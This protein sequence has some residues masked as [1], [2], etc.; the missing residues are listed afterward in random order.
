MEHDII[1]RNGIKFIVFKILREIPYIKHGFSTRIGGISE[2][3]YSYLNLGIKTGDKQN[4]VIENIKRFALS[5]GVNY[6]GLVI[7]DQIHG[8]KIEIVGNKDHASGC[9]KQKKYNG[10]DGLVT[11][12]PNTPLMATF[13]D[14]VPIFFA[15]PI[16]KVIGISHAGWKGTELKIAAKTIQIM[17]N[18]YGSKTDEIVVVIGPSIGKCCYEVD[19]VVVERFNKGFTDTSTFIFPKGKGKYQIDLWEA[20]RIILKEMGISNKNIVI[21]NLCT[22]CNLD[23]FYSHRKENG[24]TGRMGAIIQLI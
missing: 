8:D 20:N 3:A 1:N 15:D 2:G 6:E 11:N 23:L 13:A 18:E 10:V 4:N 16:K 5:V 14:C 17:I 21:S 7:S 22:G 19:D 12:V 24:N 9:V